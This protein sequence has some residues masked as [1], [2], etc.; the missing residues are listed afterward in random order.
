MKE[1]ITYGLILMII[2]AIAAG[3][4]AYVYNQTQR[5]ILMQKEKEKFQALQ[6]ILPLAKHFEN[7]NDIPKP[8]DKMVKI[9]GIYEGK[10]D[11]QKVGKIVELIIRGYSSDINL[12]VGLDSSGKIT[13]IK[14]ISQ[15]ETPGLGAEITKNEFL[16]QFI[17]KNSPNMELKKDIQPITG[18]TIS[19]RAVLRAVK[20]AL[21][22]K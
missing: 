14:I 22:I 18:A 20:E 3:A 13:K 12:L 6:E 19:S 16:D 9:V 15:Q 8:K 1:I 4:L 7:I 5:V 17:G 21:S 11:N 2:C 10:N